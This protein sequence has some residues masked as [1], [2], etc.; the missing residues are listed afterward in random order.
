MYIHKLCRYLKDI[1][2]FN[3]CNF[4]PNQKLI[5]SIVLSISFKKKSNLVASK[6]N[7]NIC[8]YGKKKKNTD[9]Q[10]NVMKDKQ[11]IATKNQHG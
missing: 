2:V 11:T 5:N 4:L 7:V 3:I 10:T 6:T 8:T 9:F 1:K